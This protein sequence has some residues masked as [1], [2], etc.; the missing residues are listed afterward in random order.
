MASNRSIV[1]AAQRTYCA[2]VAAEIVSKPQGYWRWMMEPHVDG[3]TLRYA[4]VS[5]AVLRYWNA[6]AAGVM[7]ACMAW[8]KARH[9]RAATMHER[10]AWQSRRD[11]ERFAHAM[12]H[13]QLEL[14]QR[15]WD[16][17]DVNVMPGWE[18][19]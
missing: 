17:R 16:R 6:F 8:R 14:L 3:S 2:G 12:D 10:T 15:E 1:P 7:A 4:P 9:A 13:R 18:W 5:T 11:E 19:R